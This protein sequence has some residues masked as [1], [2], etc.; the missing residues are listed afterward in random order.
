MRVFRVVL[1]CFF[2]AFALLPGCSCSKSTSEESAK[3][4]EEEQAPRPLRGLVEEHEDGKVEWEIRP[5]GKV[6]ARV[7]GADGKAIA[8][9]DVQGKVSVAGDWINLDG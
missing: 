4:A 9:A 1:A 3:P 2:A 8:L 5:E 6:R 7:S